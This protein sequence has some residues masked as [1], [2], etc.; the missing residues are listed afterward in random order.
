MPDPAIP[1]GLDRPGRRW[2]RCCWPTSSPRCPAGQAARTPGCDRARRSDERDDEHRPPRSGHRRRAARRHPG[3]AQRWPECSCPCSPS[4]S[5]WSGS[6]APG[7]LPALQAVAFGLVLVGALSGAVLA[8]ARAAGRAMAGGVRRA[9]RLGRA[10]RGADRR[11]GASGQHQAARA[12]VTLAVPL[13]IAI[14]VHML[15][16]LPDGRLAAGPGG[17]ARPWPMPP[18]RPPGW[19]WPS[20]AARSRLGG[21]GGLA[22]GRGVRPARGTAPLPGAGGTRPAADA[23][24]GGR[25]RAGGRLGAGGRRPARARRLAR[26]GRAPWRRAARSSCRSG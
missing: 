3:A 8:R 17:S 1:A 7:A 18:R 13:V 20:P 5:R 22:A 9:G 21:G 16:A 14:S 2:P 26:A 15:L 11:R 4:R 19:R 24:D 6:R 25:R 10:D 12:V 23:V